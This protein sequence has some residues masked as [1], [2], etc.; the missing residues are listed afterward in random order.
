[1]SLFKNVPYVPPDSIFGLF[2]RAQKDQRKEK[3]D[4]SIGIYHNENHEVVMMKSV[5]KAQEKLAQAEK[6]KSYLPIGGMEDFIEVSKELLFGKDLLETDRKNLFGVQTVGG[7]GALRLG[8][9]L[10]LK[11][12]TNKLFYSTPT[13]ANH[14]QLFILCGLEIAPYP[15][16]DEKKKEVA[17]EE[18]LSFFSKAPEKSVALLHGCCHNPTGCDLKQEEWHELSKVLLK[19]KILPFFDVAYQGFGQGIEEDVYPIRH[20]AKEGHEMLVA[21]SFSKT[22]GLY[23]ERTGALILRFNDDEALKNSASTLRHLIRC[24]YS[25]P[26]KHG[27]ALTALLYRD[28]HLRKKWE[29]ELKI[30]RTRLDRLRTLLVDN[31]SKKLGNSSFSFLKERLGMFSLLGLK[32]GQVETLIQEYAIY[33]SKGGRINLSNLDEKNI[34]HVIQ[35]LLSITK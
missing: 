5:K 12:V 35:A 22:C 18:M 20:F 7:T 27:A 14:L 4:L 31:L 11:H 6:N 28:P 16:Y 29:E 33:M 30:I 1:M 25:N 10:F 26:P 3:I 23:A 13:W 8:G 32:E 15:Y 2:A 34:G 24:N 9:D 19:R 21:H 17:F